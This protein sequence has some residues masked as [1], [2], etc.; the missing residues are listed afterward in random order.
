M[1]KER[2]TITPSTTGN[3]FDIPF[4]NGT[5]TIPD[6][7]GGYCI[8]SGCGSGKTES[9]KSLIRQKFAKGILYCVDTVAE[10]QKMYQ[11]V[12]DELVTPGV[13]PDTDVMMINSKSDLESMKTY[14]DHPEKICEVP[15]LIVV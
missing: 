13:I 2:I 14:Q 3:G 6:T 9:I 12:H 11:W 7:P 5:V 10:C 4:P 15:I 1:A 8:S